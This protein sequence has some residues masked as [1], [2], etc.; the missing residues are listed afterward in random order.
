MTCLALTSALLLVTYCNGVY[1]SQESDLIVLTTAARLRSEIGSQ[2]NEAE[3]C[4]CE[5]QNYTSLHEQLATDIEERVTNNVR[6]LIDET[7][8]DLL[9]SQLFHLVT[10]GYSSSLP[11]SSCKE[12]LQLAPHSP[13][14]LYWIRG[15]DKQMY[16]DMERRCKGV[17]GG[18]MRLA[19]ID[20]TDPTSKCPHGLK[21]LTS[22]RRLCAKNI[23]GPGCSSAFIPVQGVEYSKVC[24]KIIG[25][26]QG[27][28]DSFH[29]FISGQTTIDSNYVDGI[30]ITRGHSPRKHIWTLAGAVHED[31]AR[32]YLTCPC[33]NTRIEGQTPAPSFVGHDYF[34]DTGSEGHFQFIFYGGDPLWDGA[35]CGE[36]NTCCSLNSP[37][38]FLKN[39][40]PPSSDDIEM[41][42]CTDQSR[43]D[44]DINF[45]TLEIY[46]Q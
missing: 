33:T 44:E 36:F 25:Y 1:S 8:E 13:S 34:C 17:G 6:A 27:T 4:R 40:Y 24:G 10:P 43:G 2:L 11:A 12:I 28:P 14:G 3:L 21:T 23:D 46:V 15:A 29:R 35:G 41:R 39:V 45:E 30:S 37:P 20:M 9:Q 22:P 38:W 42:L 31:N 19:S 32:P 18:W 5:P 16:C 26:Q 7:V